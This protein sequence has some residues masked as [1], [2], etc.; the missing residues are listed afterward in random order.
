MPQ[1]REKWVFL[2]ISFFIFAK[3]H[4]VSFFK[5]LKQKIRTFLHN[6]FFETLTK[7][8]CGLQP[9]LC[10]LKHCLHSRLNPTLSLFH[11]VFLNFFLKK[12]AYVKVFNGN[13]IQLPLASLLAFLPLI[14]LYNSYKCNAFFV[15]SREI[16]T[17]T[18][19]AKTV[20]YGFAAN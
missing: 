15:K 11:H 20:F 14:P 18:I 12:K 8:L 7:F 6:L 5:R 10:S 9:K 2:I 13:H 16:I 3:V 17:V 4:Y 19:S 1:L